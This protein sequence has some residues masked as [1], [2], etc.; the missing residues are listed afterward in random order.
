MFSTKNLRHND[1][2]VSKF[3]IKEIK[4]HVSFS[5]CL[6]FLTVLQYYSIIQYKYI[7]P[8]PT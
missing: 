2:V 5:I 7:T 6:F 8:F 3:V 1:D 4:W